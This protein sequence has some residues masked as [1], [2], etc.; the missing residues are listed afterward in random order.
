MD[1]NEIFKNDPRRKELLQKIIDA[2]DNAVV[3]HK[4]DENQN[5]VAV[6]DKYSN[7]QINKLIRELRQYEWHKF[8]VRGGVFPFPLVAN[9]KLYEPVVEVEKVFDLETD[10]LESLQ[11][12]LKIALQKEDFEECMRLDK[13]IKKLKN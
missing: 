2:Y 5:I 3:S 12:Q 4:L 7:I 13:K 1:S 6:Y 8:D 9:G 10:N 11:H